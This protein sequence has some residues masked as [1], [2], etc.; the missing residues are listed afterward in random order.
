[1]RGHG[2][3]GERAHGAGARGQG[4]TYAHQTLHDSFHIMFY[5][6]ADHSQKSP[7]CGTS[8]AAKLLVTDL[9]RNLL[10][11]YSLQERAEL[12]NE[13]HHKLMNYD[14]SY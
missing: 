13:P 5:I 9:D 8:A 7:G 12:P 11:M 3:T 2:G 1:M 10:Y 14:R 4:H 6:R